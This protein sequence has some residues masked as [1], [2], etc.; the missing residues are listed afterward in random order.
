MRAQVDRIGAA[1]WP[2]L[3]G[4]LV[5][6]RPSVPRGGRRRERTRTLLA[7]VASLLVLVL[8]PAA[9]VVSREGAGTNS[10][11]P[12]GAATGGLGQP[13]HSPGAVAGTHGVSPVGGIS[14]ASSPSAATAPTV[15][16]VPHASSSSGPGGATPGAATAYCGEGD[17]SIQTVTDRA[18]YPSGAAVTIT[19]RLKNLSLNACL[20]YTDPCARSVSVRD[21]G[22]GEIWSSNPSHVY[23]CGGTVVV[24]P[25]PGAASPYQSVAPGQNLDESY[26]WD[27]RTCTNYPNPATCPGPSASPGSYTADGVWGG[28][29]GAPSRSVS[30]GS[31]PHFQLQ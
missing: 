7:M 28:F 25:T 24:N 29:D 13:G 6:V 21:S 15:G 26:S 30:A 19:M 9:V 1:I 20:V 31:S 14:S 18:A 10:V 27:R 16:A 5:K 8:V 12:P 17:V 22:G 11:P 3:E 2:D 23:R 4:E